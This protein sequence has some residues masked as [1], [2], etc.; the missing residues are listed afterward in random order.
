MRDARVIRVG[1][2]P[3]LYLTVTLARIEFGAHCN[4]SLYIYKLG[5]HFGLS[6]ID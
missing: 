4:L 3:F 5:L 1:I 6:S 2:P